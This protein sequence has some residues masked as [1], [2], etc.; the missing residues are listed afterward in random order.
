[1]RAPARRM[2]GP[3]ARAKLVYPCPARCNPSRRVPVFAVVRRALGARP[4]DTGIVLQAGNGAQGR[5]GCVSSRAAML[6]S[7]L[8]A[9]VV[10]RSTSTHSPPSSKGKWR[11]APAA[12]GRPISCGTLRAPS[13]LSPLL[14]VVRQGMS[15]TPDASNHRVLNTNMIKFFCIALENLRK[16][17]AGNSAC[18]K[19]RLG[20]AVS[21]SLSLSLSLSPSLLLFLLSF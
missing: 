18:Q 8:L 5:G 11:S 12:D 17:T 19:Q 16:Q 4:S 7:V 14:P 9:L 21:L 2:D 15:Q 6:L 1:M 13:E 10:S 20:Q 3:P